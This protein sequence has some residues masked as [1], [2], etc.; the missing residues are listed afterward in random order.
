M[1]CLPVTIR[2]IEAAVDQQTEEGGDLKFY[3]AEPAMLLLVAAVDTVA[4]QGSSLEA[5]L[6]DATG[7]IKARYFVTEPQPKDLG[8][9]VQGR[10]LSLYGSVRTAPAVHF[11]V[12]GLRVVRS[13]DEISYH[14]IECARAA[15]MLRRGAAEPGTPSPKKLASADVAMGPSPVKVAETPA[16]SAALTAQAAGSEAKKVWGPSAA[17]LREAVIATLRKEGEGRE[18]GVSVVALHAL[19]PAG[20]SSE[21]VRAA[22]NKLVEDGDA[23]ATIDDDHFLLAE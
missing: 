22:V 19:L 18:E 14:M 15:L 21:D 4:R 7:R 17:E 11:A 8:E 1:T 2:S 10:Y 5:T 16:Q 3:G 9:V 6:N 20:T 12:T 13:A 23:Y